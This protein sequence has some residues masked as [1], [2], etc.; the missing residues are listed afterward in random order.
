MYALKLIGWLSEMV[1]SIHG[2]YVLRYHPE[3]PESE[4]VYEIDFTPPFRR[5]DMLEELGRRLGVALPASDTLD[6]AGR[7]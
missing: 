6:T 1:H 3:G 4:K 5:V 7:V 2:S